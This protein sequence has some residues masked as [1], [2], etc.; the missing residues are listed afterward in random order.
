MFRNDILSKKFETIAFITPQ[1]AIGG[2]ETYI[3]RKSRWLIN[4]GYKVIVVS[5]GGDYVSLLHTSVKHF[6]IK[7]LATSSFHI[8][9]Y[10]VS[11]IVKEL[12]EILISEKVE[13]IESH[14][15][16][17]AVYTAMSYPITKIPF[18]VN[19]LIDTAFRRNLL[20]FVLS[21]KIQQFELLYAIS[22]QAARILNKTFLSKLNFKVLNIPIDTPKILKYSEKSR[23][24]ILSV[25]RFSTGKKYVIHL[26]E[27]FIKQCLEGYIPEDVDLLIIGDG[28]LFKEIE[29]VKNNGNENFSKE[30]IFLLGF[31][32]SE[33]LDYYYQNCT[34][35][36]GM[37]TTLLTA[38]SFKK[39]C[40][41][42]GF[43]EKTE[44]YSWGFWGERKIHNEYL[45][46][47]TSLLKD[48]KDFSEA[49]K[50]FFEEGFEYNILSEKAYEMYKN[51]F[52]LDEIMNSWL[53][54]YES[55]FQLRN[56]K[57]YSDKMIKLSKSLYS[58]NSFLFFIYQKK[59]SKL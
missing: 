15:S 45:A 36:V 33:R 38:A 37:G 44:R 56:K 20:L 50:F 3:I 23:R 51:Y 58:M 41:I 17:A 16:F 25:S 54:A 31:V 34:L 11:K 18:I 28:P 57:S 40:L 53:M 47:D 13:V 7:G 19:I 10:D 35:Y 43:Q 55:A 4:N 12:S 27:D 39:P 9:N 5:S 29:S 48:R 6:E 8:S 30:R 14:N 42:A 22:Y 21:K 1:M 24:F 52:S 26:I 59:N 46:G 49:L 2:A 32:K